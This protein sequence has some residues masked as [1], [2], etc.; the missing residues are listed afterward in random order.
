M[1]LFISYLCVCACLVCKRNLKLGGAF[2]KTE[3]EKDY[4]HLRCPPSFSSFLF[5]VFLPPFNWS[6]RSCAD[7]LRS[8]GLSWF[9]E[10]SWFEVRRC[11]R[12]I[13]CISP[14]E[15]RVQWSVYG[16]ISHQAN[17]SRRSHDPAR[18]RITASDCNLSNWACKWLFSL[19][20][21][22]TW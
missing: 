6:H 9:R 14:A 5:F 8:S 18:R 19:E 10:F 11:T 20:Y 15:R 22:S 17:T 12:V 13:S 2:K 4:S 21:Q 16:H 1:C 3:R 7:C